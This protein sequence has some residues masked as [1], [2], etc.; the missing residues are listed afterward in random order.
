MKRPFL[1]LFV[2][3]AVLG[4][5]LSACSGTSAEPASQTTATRKPT[6]TFL[7]DPTATPAPYLQVDLAE[8]RGTQITFLHGWSGKRANETA[9]LVDQFNQTN[10][11]GI[12]VI[13]DAPGSHRLAYQ[14]LLQTGG[15]TPAPALAA[16]RSDDLR[17]WQASSQKLVDISGYSSLPQIGLPLTSSADFYPALLAETREGDFQF[18]L[19]AAGNL[20]LLIYNQGWARELGFAGSPTSF[21]DFRQQVCAAAQAS[22][23]GVGGWLVSTSP[24]TALAWLSALGAEQ[25]FDGSAFT[26]NTDGAQ[27][28][29]LD[30]SA[31]FSQGCAWNGRALTPYDYFAA[32][33]TL[34]YSGT[35]L[36]LLPQAQVNKVFAAADTW[37]ALPYPG[38]GSSAVLADGDAYAV[39]EST[40]EQQ[41]AAWL[42]IRWMSQPG[43]QARLA[44]ADGS[45][46][47]G[48]QALQEMGKFGSENPQWLDA[49]RL[50]EDALSAPVSPFWRE[51]RLILQDALWSLLQPLPATATPMP[52]G[53][54]VQLI[55][56]ELDLTIADVIKRGP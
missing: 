38:E 3:T 41:M 16:T 29:F 19:P 55:L 12:F 45:L 37:T 43:M 6:A 22:T 13:V 33:Q 15:D 51:V 53:D 4:L 2:L 39:L 1:L 40:P 5:V 11:W 28:A 50:A 25:V 8:L 9:A 23:D 44:A 7:P 31:L 49:V 17:A 54:R 42:F 56:R 30:L 52:P 46:P 36:D 21:V 27:K 48:K 18:G 34:A 14:K 10:E 24:E 26:F 35:L 20:H 32:R 47:P